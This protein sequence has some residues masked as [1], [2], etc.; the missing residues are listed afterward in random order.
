MRNATWLR[1]A[2]MCSLTLF[3]IAANP[4]LGRCDVDLG[5]ADDE[6][7]KRPNS[8]SQLPKKLAPTEAILAGDASGPASRPG[9]S[10][11][12]RNAEQVE[13]VEVRVQNLGNE[14]GEG[15]VYVD[16]LDETG[17]I[18]LHL[19]PPD[20]QKVVRLPA[21]DRGGRQGKILRMKASHE[22]NTLIDRYDRVRIRYGVRATIE[23]VGKDKNPFDNSKIKSWNI[24]FTVRPGFLNAYNYIYKNHSDKAVKVRWKFEHT[25]YPAGWEIKGFPTAEKPF[26][27]QPGQQ[28]VGHLTML[29]PEKIEEGAFL[30]ARLSLVNDGDGSLFQQ[31]EWF[32]V[33]DTEPPHVSNYRVILTDDHR[34]AIQALISD[35]GSGVLEATGVTTEFSSDGGRTW[36]TRAHNYKNGNF[37]RPTLFETVLGPFAPDTSIQVRL[38]ARD[39]AGNAQTVIPEDASGITAPPKAGKLLLEKAYI[40]PRTRPNPIF[41]LTDFNKLKARKADLQL[42]DDD[43]KTLKAIKPLELKRLANPAEKILKM[44]TLELK[45]K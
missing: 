2:G 3:A 42:S 16:V 29:A 21:A 6:T 17:K 9:M 45:V 8:W 39:T 24:P 1:F 26:E 15:K 43:L 23:T 33:Y 13:E 34:V 40:F 5:I 10:I 36:A 25:P 38:S 12:W 27:L 31:H 19:E 7:F 35:K 32:Q 14:A 20:D 37:V 4:R 22:L 11:A 44:T 30:E 28:L 41:D 18:L